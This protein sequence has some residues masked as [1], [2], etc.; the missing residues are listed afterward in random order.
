MNLKPYTYD[1]IF[2]PDEEVDETTNQEVEEASKNHVGFMAQDLLKDFPHVVKHDEGEDKYS[3]NY[4]GLIPELEAA[5]QE[6]N[7]KIEE[8]QA[9]VEELKNK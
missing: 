5:L 6:Q 3:V 4:I 9:I 2:T 7:R 1:F 8:L